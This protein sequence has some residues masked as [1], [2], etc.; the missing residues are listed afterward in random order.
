[1]GQE[2]WRGA[3]F[4]GRL[5]LGIGANTTPQWQKGVAFRSS[6][7]NSSWGRQEYETRSYC[8]PLAGSGQTESCLKQ[9][10]SSLVPRTEPAAGKQCQEFP[11]A[12]SR[13]AFH[14]DRFPTNLSLARVK[15]C[16]GNWHPSS[17][18]GTVYDSQT[19]YGRLRCPN[20][21]AGVAQWTGAHL[22]CWKP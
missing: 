16:A 3:Q 15:C 6:S 13:T 17:L 11:A 12:G 22:A 4:L 20:K 10:G 18:H 21:A 8:P 19:T 2:C 9:R 1:M 14:F 7:A 5:G